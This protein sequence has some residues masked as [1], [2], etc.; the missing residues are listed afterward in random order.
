L[1]SLQPSRNAVEM[2]GVVAYSPGDCALFSGGSTLVCLT[3]NAQVH[4]VIPADGAVVDHDI[5]SP[6][7]HC[8]PLQCVSMPLGASDVEFST[9]LTSN[10]F[11]LSAL[12]SA[13]PDLDALDTALDLADAAAAAASCISTSAILTVLR[14]GS[15]MVF[16]LN[17]EAIR[18]GSVGH[19]VGRRRRVVEVSGLDVVRRELWCLMW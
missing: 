13:A 2:E 14:G 12:A 6:Q 9:F 18:S 4:D 16:A 17:W 3:F 10:F 15:R 1:P 19:E 8:I 7:C 5:P 11:L